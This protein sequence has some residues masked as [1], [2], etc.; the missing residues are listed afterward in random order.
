MKT[1]NIW[2]TTATLAVCGLG[3]AQAQAQEVGRVLVT[4]PIVHQVPVPRQVCTTQQVEAQ[5]QKSGAGALMGAIAGGAIG[6][7]VGQGAGNAVATMAGI[8]GG[9]LLGDHI[10][11]A[12][13]AQPQTVQSC[14]TQNF[15]ETRTVGYN[16]TYEFAGRQYTSRMS[17]DPGPT[18]QLQVMPAASQVPFSGG[19]STVTYLPA[20][21]EN[22]E[23]IVQP[24]YRHR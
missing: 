20:V 4:Q 14:T 17:Q 2:I 8:V 15:M 1:R 22:T 19:P 10:E 7:Q 18:I 5:P 23:V 11:G 21:V 13:P 9:A 3:Q 24:V 12:P 6:N 16:V